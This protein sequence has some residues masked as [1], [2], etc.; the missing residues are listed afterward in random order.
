MK[1]VKWGDYIYWRFTDKELE[2]TDLDES[3][4]LPSSSLFRTEIEL[5]KERKFAEADKIVERIEKE[6]DK[7]HKLRESQKKP[8]KKGWFK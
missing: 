4:C 1:Y 3:K 6:E 7:D 8:K 2:V 5:I